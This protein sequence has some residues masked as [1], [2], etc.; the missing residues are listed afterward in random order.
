MRKELNLNRGKKILLSL[1]KVAKGKKVPIRFEDIVVQSFREF[2]GD[3]QL[4]GYPQYPDSGDIVHK[5]LYTDLKKNGFLTSGEKYFT[6]TDKGIRF[7]RDNILNGNIIRSDEGKIRKL[8]KD[9][10][11]TLERI[12]N[13]MALALFIQKKED[14]ILDVDFYNFLGA[15][16]RTKKYDFISKL[17]DIKDLIDVLNHNKNPLGKILNQLNEFLEKKFSKNIEFAT[18]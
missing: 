9:E 10:E 5:P 3:F 2:P 4:R 18:K 11:K 13:S 17:N 1:Y 7:V 8:T 6:L 14:E 15:S 12:K 16:V